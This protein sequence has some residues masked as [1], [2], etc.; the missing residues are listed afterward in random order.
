MIG[1]IDLTGVGYDVGEPTAP[2]VV[3]NFSDFGCP[4]CGQFT[5]ETYPVLEREYVRTGKIFFKY[6]PFVMGMF[7]HGDQ[8][9]LASECAGD[10]G[11]FWPMHAQLYERQAEWKKASDAAGRFQSYAT[12]QGIDGALFGACYA[13]QKVHRRTQRA[14]Q[15]ANSIGVRVTPSFIVG[16]RPIEGALPIADFRRVIDAALLLAKAGR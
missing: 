11:R 12:A 8:A 4:Y 16:G 15:V 14:N 5:R 10:Q 6:V 2:V 13:D 1:D 3:I 7:P 9:A